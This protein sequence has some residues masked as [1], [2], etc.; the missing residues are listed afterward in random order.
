MSTKLNNFNF[1]LDLKHSGI[2]SYD[3]EWSNIML[4]VHNR[5]VTTKLPFAIDFP[6]YTDKGLGDTIRIFSDSKDN[7]NLILD[8]S[9][10]EH[11]EDP[12]DAIINNN[13]NVSN[14]YAMHIKPVPQN[15]SK[16]A[17]V[18]R[19]GVKTNRNKALRYSKKHNIT[20]ND[21]ILLFNNSCSNLPFINMYSSSTRKMFP[22]FINKKIMNKM[23]LN[24]FNSYG[25]SLNNSTI[26]IF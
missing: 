13:I 19:K 23:D 21:A 6:N 4:Y 9:E 25:L 3:V 16:Y 11:L 7:L 10:V 15:I 1:Y 5:I 22:L 24:T 20:L 26:P 12:I 14:I 18:S 8:L 2:D 17:I